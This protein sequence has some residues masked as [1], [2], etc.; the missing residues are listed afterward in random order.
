[1]LKIE[2]QHFCGITFCGF[3]WSLGEGGI[4][5]LFLMDAHAIPP[6]KIKSIISNQRRMNLPSSISVTGEICDGSIVVSSVP[7][8]LRVSGKQP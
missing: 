3:G 2:Q 1:M 4:K 6:V 8:G 5:R 7:L